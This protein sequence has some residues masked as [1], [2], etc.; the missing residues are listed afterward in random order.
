MSREAT[1]VIRANDKTK[2]AFSSVNANLKGMKSF[3]LAA[4]GAIGGALAV[5]GIGRALDANR[6]LIDSLA[7]MSDKT[8]VATERL[9]AY[10][11]AAIEGGGSVKGMNEALTK[12]STK[13]SEAAIIGTG[14]TVDWL[15]KMKL[16]VD[17]LKKLSPDE[18]FNKYS[19]SINGLNTRGEKL[20]AITALMGG[21]SRSLINVIEGGSP[22]IDAM[23]KELTE[24]GVSITRID[25]AKIEAANDA[26]DRTK[27]VS[28]GLATSFS[29]ALAPVL[30]GI[31]HEYL[32]IAREAGGAG[33][34]ANKIVGVMVKGA[35]HV[36]NSVQGIT[37][38]WSAVKHGAVLAISKVLELLTKADSALTSFVNKYTPWTKEVSQSII[39]LNES[40]LIMVSESSEKLRDEFN[41]PLNSAVIDNW[42]SNVVSK[43]EK[44]AIKVAEN[45]K[46]IFDSETNQTDTD[47]PKLKRFIEDNKI[48][49]D[50]YEKIWDSSF[51]TFTK[52]MG[53]S[54]GSALVEQKSFSQALEN[55]SKSIIKQVISGL[56]QI[57]VQ[58]LAL[59]GI[60]KAGQAASLAS[61]LATAAGITAAYTAPATLVSLATFGGN[62]VPASAGMLSTAAVAQGIAL[63]GVAHDGLS[64]V[65][66]DGTYLL[67]RG[68]KVVSNSDTKKLDKLL[69][70]GGGKVVNLNVSINAIDTQN[71]TEFLNRNMGAVVGMVQDAFN[72]RGQPGPLG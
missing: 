54:V 50:A 55:L 10:H 27:F 70:Q 57:G 16:D 12:M 30:E 29:V 20:A 7:K 58:K 37:L 21:K 38:A 35:G 49:A 33:E 25:A 61:G 56:V 53:D 46:I 60:E 3:A 14:A 68:E 48:A 22:I 59:K 39:E 5:R 8:G 41:K 17:E 43:S 69:E 24:L 72:D 65:P 13:L 51:K 26:M 23:E 19:N 9:Q 31:A 18:L 1:I 64:S 66:T 28:Q 63:T 36:A 47:N 2:K 40:M 11:Q 71:G 52:G 15:E 32:N 45:R 6:Q 42:Y 4:T 62:S 44:A 34:L 67:E